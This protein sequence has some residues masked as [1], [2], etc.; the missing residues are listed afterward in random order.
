M[1]NSK[2]RTSN[3]YGAYGFNQGRNSSRNQRKSVGCGELDEI[4]STNDSNGDE[5]YDVDS[6]RPSYRQSTRQTYNKALETED[7]Y[8]IEDGNN[9]VRLTRI[10]G[11]EESSGYCCF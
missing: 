1:R 4:Q 11:G 3:F 5:T 10:R 7:D 2:M 6:Y 8:D 9:K